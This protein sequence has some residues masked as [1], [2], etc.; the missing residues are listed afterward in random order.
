MLRLRFATLPPCV[1]RALLQASE[2][3]LMS[4]QFSRRNVRRGL[5]LL[6]LV[7]VIGIL[8]L[9]AG[10][11]IPKIADLVGR[12]R[13]STQAY[14]TADV[15]RQL[16]IFIGMNQK[17]PDGWDTLTGTSGALYEKLHSGLTAST[18]T[19]GSILTTVT[20]TGDQITSLNTAGISHVFLHDAT[21]P[22][23]FSGTDRR[24]FA[25]TG[26]GDGTT[27]ISQVAV[28]NE[29]T[30]S[31]GLDML[32]NSFG[33]NP[34]KPANDTTYP[35]ISQN[36]Y[37]V[38]GLGPKST[39]VQ[40]QIQE[41]PTLENELSQTTYSRALAV[42]EVPDSGGGKAKLVG[43]FGPDGRTKATALSDYGN[44]NGP[45]PH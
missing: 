6:E 10:L 13:S 7:V 42:F 34:N 14:S 4:T 35:R 44:K 26:H 21:S 3:R 33:L 5:T 24:H 38:F 29:A 16:E 40:T 25:G 22:P 19:A 36:I 27:D 43:V 1:V 28:V 23:S 31:R 18:G 32:V 39:I 41:A 2:D 12:S 17:Y 20:L 30:G 37:V 15:S 9:L 8:A 11:T 45:Q